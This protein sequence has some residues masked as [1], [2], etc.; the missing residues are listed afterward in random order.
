M[1][2][3]LADALVSLARRI[4]SDCRLSSYELAY[5]K[6]L[7][8]AAQRGYEMTTLVNSLDRFRNGVPTKP[9]LAIRHDVDINCVE[10]NRMFFRV[11]QAHRAT[12]TYY[13]RL[14][15]AMAHH[16]F[17]DQLLQAGFEVGYHYEEAADVAKERKLKTREEV[18]SFRDEIQ[19][20]FKYN[21]ERFRKRY[22]SRMRSVCSHGDWINRRLRF[23]NKDLLDK[24]V[25]AQC[26]ID[27][28]A[29]DGDF[30]SYFGLYLSDVQLPPEK[31]RGENDWIDKLGE[32]PGSIYVLAHER[33]WYPAPFV[34]NREN[35]KRLI[36][37]IFYHIPGR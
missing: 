13:F 30:K 19:E 14:S 33:Q 17:I 7:Q 9:Y 11:E 5:S 1:N 4:H 35:I 21:C 34:K 18:F 8:A 10:G 20:R 3:L 12:A 37:S 2:V 28:E 27:L 31:W 15:T 25:L 24:R 26:G 6:F 32:I 23:I 36:E 16:T 29:Y 22:S